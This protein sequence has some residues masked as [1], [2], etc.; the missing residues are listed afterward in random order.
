MM[1]RVNG[2]KQPWHEG[3]TVEDL[4]RALDDPYPYAAV[5]IDNRLVSKPNFKTFLIADDS[6]VFLIP[7][8]SGG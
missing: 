2:K 7:L 8:I 4:L 5:R 1:I 3:M 6:E